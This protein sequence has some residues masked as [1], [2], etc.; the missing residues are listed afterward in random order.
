MATIRPK[1]WPMGSDFWRSRQLL[2][3]EIFDPSTPSKNGGRMEG[4]KMV[5][6]VAITANCWCQFWGIFLPL[7]IY[8]AIIFPISWPSSLATSN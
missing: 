6:L 5:F 3:N 4:G 1:K 8:V 2:R 7:V